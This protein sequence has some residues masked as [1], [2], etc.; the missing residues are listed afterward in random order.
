[1]NVWVLLDIQNSVNTGAILSTM[2]VSTQRLRHLAVQGTFLFT[3]IFSTCIAQFIFYQGAGDQRTLLLP[4][5]NYL[6]MMLVGLIP[7][8]YELEQ[9]DTNIQSA[10]LNK[11]NGNMDVKNDQSK[12]PSSSKDT[13]LIRRMGLDFI[14]ESLPQ[15]TST[16]KNKSN[17][18]HAAQTYLRA[19]PTQLC[20]MLSVVLDFAGC[21]F[22]NTGLSMA[23]SGL[24]QVVYSSVICW[25]AFISRIALRKQ[26]SRE[27]WTGIALVTFGLSY[28]ALGESKNDSKD[29]DMVLMGCLNTLLGAAFYGANY[30]MGEYMFTLPERPQAREFCLQ[31]GTI[32]VAIIAVYQ[33]IFVLPSWDNLITKPVTEANGKTM[34]IVMALFAYTMS[35]LVHGFTYFMMLEASGAVTTGIMQSLRAVCVFLLSSI[36]YCSYQ[37]SQCFD[38]K[39]GVATLIV[40]SGVMVYS[41]A[42]RLTNDKSHPGEV[43]RKRAAALKNC[44]V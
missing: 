19:T 9:G 17:L 11:S 36:L 40:V 38:T 1:M 12:K 16:H 20:I 22:S 25:S 13:M 27:Q 37:E 4:L 31:I 15:R 14:A 28:S 34:S 18:L 24:F 3:G 7:D 39:R 33:I 29:Y 42:K 6:G 43:Q 2:H 41:L 10:Y 5:C 26:V 23:G 8:I 44:V 30:V 21:V 35:Q 32:C